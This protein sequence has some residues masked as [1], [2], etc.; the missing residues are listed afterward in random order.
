VKALKRQA[1]GGQATA[2]A[3]QAVDG[4]LI[5]R[6]DPMERDA[7]RDLAVALRDQGLKAVVLGT[8]PDGG[9]AA[10]VAAVTAESGLHASALLE[11][12]KALIKGGGGKDPLLAVAGG[13]DAEGLDAALASVRAAAGLPPAP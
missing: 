9:G 7:I 8:A 12:A 10:L 5:A 3:G 1:A 6:V 2:L 11:D 4:V 13:K